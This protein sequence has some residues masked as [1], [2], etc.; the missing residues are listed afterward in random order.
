M[1]DLT[2]ERSIELMRWGAVIAAAVVA[3]G[4]DLRWRKIPNALTGPVFLAG[5]LFS[6]WAGGFAGAG[7][8]ILGALAMGLPFVLLWLVHG[9]GAGDAKLMLALGAWLCV[10]NALYALAGVAIAGGVVSLVAAVAGNRLRAAL[11]G[12][13]GLLVHLPFVLIGPG[14]LEDRQWAV[15]AASQSRLWVPYAVSVLIG[16]CAAAAWVMWSSSLWRQA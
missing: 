16:T 7:G 5:V 9:S 12:T 3:A 11:A 8:S 14:R 2:T 13:A 10:P 1:W 6:I 15:P 4:F